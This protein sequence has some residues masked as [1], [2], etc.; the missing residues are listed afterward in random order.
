MKSERIT[1]L[2]TPEFKAYLVKEAE[3]AGISVSELIRRRCA[4]QP[5][6]D[7]AQLMALTSELQQAVKAARSSLLEGLAS[8]QEA[9]Q[10][11]KEQKVA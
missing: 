9:L 7:E 1:V 8:V 5:T 10:Q 2:S 4:R 3:K 11:S 6:E